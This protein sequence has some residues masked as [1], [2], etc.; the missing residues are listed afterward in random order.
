VRLGNVAS[1]ANGFRNFNGL[2]Q[3]HADSPVFVAGDYEGAEAKAAP[4]F[5]DFGGAVDKNH[6]FGQLGPGPAFERG[7]GSVR[8]RG[9]HPPR[10]AIRAASAAAAASGI[11][12][13]ILVYLRH[14]FLSSG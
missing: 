9:P 3:A 5:H 7:I 6:L 4:A 8:W 2:A 14:S 10:A 11:A 1:F 12:T 13:G